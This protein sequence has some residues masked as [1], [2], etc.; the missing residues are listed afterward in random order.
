MLKNIE[1]FPKR[2]G[3]FPYIYLLYLF[4]PAYSLAG[5]TGPKRWIGFLFLFIFLIS[6]RQLYSC[7]AK[8]QFHYWLALQMAIIIV[9]SISFGLYFLFLGFFTAH[10]I[11]WYQDPKKFNRALISFITVES[12]PILYFWKEIDIG[13][14]INFAPFLLIMIMSPYGIKS[15]NKR[16][17]LEKQLAQANEQ[18][19]DLVKREERLRIARDLHDT[20][21]HTLS[22]ITLKS[23]LVE[24]LTTRSP[25]RAKSEAKEIEQISRSALQQ[26][27][28]LVSN[29]RALSMADELIRV[30]EL[31]QAGSIDCHYDGTKDFDEVPPLTQNIFSMCLR[32][33]A[34]NVIKHSKA[35]NCY[36]SFRP[37][38]QFL[39]LEIE[40]DGI[41]N[42]SEFILGNGL[43][44]MQER[45]DLIDGTVKVCG[46]Q[47]AKLIFE[48][49]VIQKNTKEGALT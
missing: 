7:P 1:F 42:G 10:F 4:L 24:R 32:E 27:R 9:M 41:G 13:S 22:L 37:S 8:K 12:I 26:V 28:E 33:A 17:E 18:I 5:E 39:T 19:K 40:D 2:F 35:S 15:M 36:I 14:L 6:Y 46:T 34:T 47:G 21:G 43:T 23:Q 16:I 20:L 44:G 45:L 3:I 48:V 38:H 25:E 49:P 29:M 30:Q 31:L 11:G